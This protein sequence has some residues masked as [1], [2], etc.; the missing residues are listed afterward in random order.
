MWVAREAFRLKKSNC[1]RIQVEVDTTISI[2]VD[3]NAE[4]GLMVEHGFS[5]WIETGSTRILFDTGQ[6]NTLEN[7]AQIMGIG[8]EAT[9]ILVLSH[10]HYDHT[11]GVAQGLHHAEKA[12]V[13]CHPG[14]VHPRYGVRNGIPAPLQM[15]HATMVAIDKLPWDRLRW[16]QSVQFLSDRIG[17]TGPIPRKTAYEDTGG[18]FFLDPDGRRPDLM[19]DEIALWIR[20]DSGLVVCVGCA[21]AGI[22]N[23]LQ[24]IQNLNDG[25]RIR[26]V[27]GGF[28]LL[29][30]D[31]S[32]IE[33][34]IT[35]LHSFSLDCIVP[36]H[37]TGTHAVEGLNKEFG[38]VCHPGAAGMV[39]NF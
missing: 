24:Y 6:G 7:N 36:C 37:C 23:T 8:L 35:A 20:T 39:L 3:N 30:A 34:T 25:T 10:G 5:L 2:L 22:V 27:V 11:G 19:N 1:I 32:R 17:L 28:H 16:V 33:K 14:T 31:A 9:D 15:P 29:H 26:A 38:R 18:L 13:Y 12:R 4:A 21:H